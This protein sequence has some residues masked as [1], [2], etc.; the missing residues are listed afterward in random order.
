M[1]LQTTEKWKT[2]I[3]QSNTSRKYKFIINGTEYGDDS[4]VEHSVNS[5]LFEEL[6]IGGTACAQ[7]QLSL[8]ADNIPR[9]AEIHRYV[10]I[11]NN[12]TGEQSEWLPAGIFWTNRRSC[13]DGYWRIEAFDVMRRAETAWNPDQS[14]HFPMAM[15]TAAEILAA[16]IGTSLDPR[17]EVSHNYTIDY[18]ASIED[19]ENGENY[20]IRQVLQWIA[21][22]HAGN[23]IVTGEGKLLLVGIGTEPEETFLIVDEHGQPINLGGVVLF[24]DND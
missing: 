23:W 12:S 1:A 13:E 8:F 22:A 5:G 24:H 10:C 18:P 16:L 17:T 4:E 7:L 21:A 6:G 9:A 3:K 19:D 14:L 11:V 2:L 20:T 15:D